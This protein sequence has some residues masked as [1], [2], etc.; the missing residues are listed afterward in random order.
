MSDARLVR[1]ICNVLFNFDFFH[2]NRIIRTV[3]RSPIR[4]LEATFSVKS[5]SSPTLARTAR[6]PFLPAHPKTVSIMT[7]ATPLLLYSG[8]TQTCKSP[9]TS[10]LLLIYKAA[11]PIGESP[12]KAMKVERS[13]P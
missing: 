11:I 5:Q 13:D 12:E 7:I 10:I 4:K 2:E 1:V 8:H 9:P 6:K 3:E